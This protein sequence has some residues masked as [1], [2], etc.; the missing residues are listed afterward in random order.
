MSDMNSEKKVTVGQLL[1]P[2]SLLSFII[3]ILF[4]FQTTQI[5]RDRDALHETK[6]QQ[7]KPIQDSQKLQAQL[8]ALVLGT[9]KLSD[10][11]DKNAKQVIDRLK[12]LGIT[13]N[14]DKKVPAQAGAE[15]AQSP[16]PLPPAEQMKQGK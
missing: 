11:G 2:V 14:N 1:V 3:M 16:V 8:S 9:Q 7:E 4:A 5:L 15:P 12:E 13:V 10:Q 6:G